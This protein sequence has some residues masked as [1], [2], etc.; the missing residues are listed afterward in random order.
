V[1]N[2]EVDPADYGTVGKQVPCWD[3]ECPGTIVI[4]RDPRRC[5]CSVCHRKLPNADVVI[6][7]VVAFLALGILAVVSMIVLIAWVIR[8]H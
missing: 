2:R 5:I 7:S 4:H 6:K 3:R 1:S 8:R